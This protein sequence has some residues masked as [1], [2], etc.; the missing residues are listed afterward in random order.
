LQKPVLGSVSAGD[1]GHV[2][3]DQIWIERFRPFSQ[4]L[5]FLERGVTR[6]AIV[7]PRCAKLRERRGTL[8]GGLSPVRKNADVPNGC[9]EK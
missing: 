2:L 9:A 7:E 4:R 8:G 1:T 3:C 5:E 6:E